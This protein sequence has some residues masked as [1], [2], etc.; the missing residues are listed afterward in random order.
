MNR[1]EYLRLGIPHTT[2][3]GYRKIASELLGRGVYGS[4]G[5]RNF[6]FGVHALAPISL[7]Y[8]IGIKFVSP[9]FKYD[10]NATVIAT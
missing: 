7:G 9:F 1:V 4:V 3:P 2:S 8:Y 6:Y 5:L 10:P